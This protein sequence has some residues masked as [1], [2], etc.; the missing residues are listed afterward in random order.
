MN[1]IFYL[2][3]AERAKRFYLSG[4]ERSR[5]CRPIQT[6]NPCQ[7]PSRPLKSCLFEPPCSLSVLGFIQSHVAAE[8]RRVNSTSSDEV[9][10]GDG[11]L[12][13]F[14]SLCVALFIL[15]VAYFPIFPVSL[16]TETSS[17]EVKPGFFILRMEQF[18]VLSRDSSELRNVTR[19]HG[20]IIFSSSSRKPS[21][22]GL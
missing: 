4:C 5:F 6:V 22:L 15:Y 18:S 1:G 20:A 19:Q 13:L 14:T 16:T 12:P 11:H 7:L 21:L 10:G 9:I 2:R 3:T 17:S 8:H